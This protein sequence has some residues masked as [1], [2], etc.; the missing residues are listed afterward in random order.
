[1]R[2]RT[3]KSFFSGYLTTEDVLKPRSARLL[4]GEAGSLMSLAVS[5]PL[6]KEEKSSSMISSRIVR[7]SSQWMRPMSS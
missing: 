5:N 3:T 1:M 6:T 7:R 4:I 2:S